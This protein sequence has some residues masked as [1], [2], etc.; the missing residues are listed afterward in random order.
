MKNTI[1]FAVLILILGCQAPKDRS[2]DSAPPPAA[3]PNSTD[4]KV[5]TQVEPRVIVL[6]ETPL[7]LQTD[8]IGMRNQMIRENLAEQSIEKSFSFFNE[9]ES[10]LNLTILGTYFEKHDCLSDDSPILTVAI[11]SKNSQTRTKILNFEKLP[12]LG[13]VKAAEL[14]R[15]TITMTNP[16]QCKSLKYMFKV[17]A[18]KFGTN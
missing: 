13:K 14:I 9:T 5:K 12:D 10:T 2:G 11:I 4:P 1:L 15:I 8:Q 18:E 17:T 16:G 3:I 7:I 6:D